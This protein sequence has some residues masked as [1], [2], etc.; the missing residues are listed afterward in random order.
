[1]KYAVINYNGFTSVIHAK[2]KDEAYE[3]NVDT[4]DGECCIILTR[5]EAFKMAHAILN[6]KNI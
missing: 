4:N 6:S 5:K 2:S 3:R 1:M